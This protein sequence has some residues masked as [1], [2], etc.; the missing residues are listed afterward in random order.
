MP[1]D[2]RGVAAGDEP[3]AVVSAEAA[4]GQHAIALPRRD[5]RPELGRGIEG[6]ADPDALRL[7]FQ[8]LDELVI[9]RGLHQMA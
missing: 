9:D 7:P 6:I 4:I 2:R 3:R 8:F 5:H 1:G